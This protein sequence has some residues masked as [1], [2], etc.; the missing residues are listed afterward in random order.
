MKLFLASGNLHKVAELQS[1]AAETSPSVAIESARTV[2]GMPPVVED[3]GTFIGNARKKAR[4]LKAR[5]PADGWALADDSGICVAELK[6]EPGVE[7]AY[8]AG[9]QGDDVANLNKLVDVMRGV[10]AERRRAHYVCV[11]VLISPAGDE[12]VFQG[13]CHGRLLDNPV[14][15]G[16]FG[17][18]PLFVPDGFDCTFGQLSAET[19]QAHSHRANAWRALAKWLAEKPA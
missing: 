5:L 2:G 15:S 4:A 18:D 16:G 1:L 19:K 3:T 7:S 6:G 10:P 13:E 17:Y 8:F 14:G 11:L 12:M 9:P